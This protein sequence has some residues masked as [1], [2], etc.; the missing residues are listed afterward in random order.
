MGERHGL[1]H[2]ST[3][4]GDTRSITLGSL[5]AA[6]TVRVQPLDS[7]SAMSDEEL[8]ALIREHL[9]I[10]AG[11]EFA[12]SEVAREPPKSTKSASSRATDGAGP[13]TKQVDVDQFV[14]L[15][16]ELVELERDAEVAAAEDGLS[17]CTPEMAQGKGRVLLNLRLDDAEGGLLGRTLLTLVRN[18]GAPGEDAL[19]PHKFSPHDI[20][21][22]RAAKGEPGSPALAQGIVYRVKES[23]IIIAVD[24]VPEDGLDVPLKLEKLANKVTYDRLR[25]A[26]QGL[27]YGA[28]TGTGACGPLIDV[29]FN[30]RPPRFATG[31]VPWT[32]VNDA[33]DASQRGAVAKALA[34]ADLA[35]IH[36]PPGTGKTTAVVSCCG[37]FFCFLNALCNS[38]LIQTISFACTFTLLHSSFNASALFPGVNNS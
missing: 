5:D 30:R 38:R 31:E 22:V 4:D 10:D 33:L 1:P 36:G 25:K 23:S 3:G 21:R 16:E 14:R 29:M 17:R 19:P 20:V 8:V 35:L 7:N 26:L 11:P 13:G 12:G 37:G 9:S 6:A 28:A 34:A 15:M 18:K 2:T 32:P 27:G 24:D